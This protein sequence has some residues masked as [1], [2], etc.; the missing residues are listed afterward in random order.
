[1]PHSLVLEDPLNY[2]AFTFCDALSQL[3]SA[4]TQRL[5]LYILSAKVT[6]LQETKPLVRSLSN[7]EY[8]APILNIHVVH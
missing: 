2:S 8:S 4:L 6:L 5:T 7:G 3:F 1:M